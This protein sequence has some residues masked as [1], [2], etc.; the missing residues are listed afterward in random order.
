MGLVCVALFPNV[1]KNSA[2][3]MVKEASEIRRLDPE[4]VSAI[5]KLPRLGIITDVALDRIP[6]MGRMVF[7]FFRLRS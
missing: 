4:A 6:H 7:R 5:K 3:R 2:Q 1:E